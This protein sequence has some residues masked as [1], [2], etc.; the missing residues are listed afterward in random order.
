MWMN[1]DANARG[2]MNGHEW[3]DV[4]VCAGEASGG[5][6]GVS[7]DSTK[8]T[9]FYC[10]TLAAP[11]DENVDPPATAKFQCAPMTLHKWRPPPV[12]LWQ[13]ASRIPFKER[14]L[15]AWNWWSSWAHNLPSL[16]SFMIVFPFNLF[17]SCSFLF[18]LSQEV[19]I[20]LFNYHHLHHLLLLHHLLYRPF[21]LHSHTT[22]PLPNPLIGWIPPHQYRPTRW[23]VLTKRQKYIYLIPILLSLL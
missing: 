8:S 11:V 7:S 9:T 1:V 2:G 12:L 23:H 21:L 15:F 14:S 20:L 6:V 3:A 16:L 10:S 4:D 5:V 19:L 17:I 18:M 22:P 13:T